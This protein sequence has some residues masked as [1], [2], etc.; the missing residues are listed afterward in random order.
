MD[1]TSSSLAMDGRARGRARRVPSAVGTAAHD[2]FSRVI[3]NARPIFRRPSHELTAAGVSSWWLVAAGVLTIVSYLGMNWYLTEQII[4]AYQMGRLEQLEGARDKQELVERLIERK[5]ASPQLREWLLAESSIS[6]GAPARVQIL[7]LFRSVAT[8]QGDD[9]R[10]EAILREHATGRLRRSRLLPF[11]LQAETSSGAAVYDAIASSSRY[12]KDSLARS[13]NAREKQALIETLLGRLLE[14]T[15]SPIR[16][17]RR[18]NGSIQALTVFLAWFTLILLAWRW[19]L[20]RRIPASTTPPLLLVAED[21]PRFSNAH[22]TDGELLDV[23]HLLEANH[24]AGASRAELTMI[25]QEELQRFLGSIEAKVYGVYEFL[26]GCLPSL[27]FIGT[28]YGM[29]KALLLA[30]GL[31]SADDRQRT[32]TLMTQEL[33]FA[34]D[35]TLIALIASLLVGLAIAAVRQH[36]W[37]LYRAFEKGLVLRFLGEEPVNDAR[38][39]GEFGAP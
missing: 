18:L 36:E 14:E 10:W 26:L 27:G 21:G 38:P 6:P 25:L 24:A 1:Q 19:W 11:V 31:L 20:L 16:D 4:A 7:A 39:A 29:G 3:K 9:V 13:A 32:I 30:D 23:L 22:R 34:F 28:V 33:G 5:W 2:V 37:R 35:T 15:R 8:A 17:L 12:W